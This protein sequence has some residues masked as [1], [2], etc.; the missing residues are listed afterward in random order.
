MQEREGGEPRRNDPRSGQRRGSDQYDEYNEGTDSSMTTRSP[1]APERQEDE[2]SRPESGGGWSGYVVPYRY[3][4]PGYRGVGYYSVMYQGAGEGEQAESESH[5]EQGSARYAQGSSW[6]PR[7]GASGG[8]RFGAG[9]AGRGPKGYQRSDERLKEEVSDRLMADDQIDASDIEVEVQKGEVT[10]TGTVPD[11]RSKRQ[12]ED[13]AEQVMGVRD[14][15]NQIR[16]KGGSGEGG[17]TDPS[18]SETRSVSGS[19]PG[20]ASSQQPTSDRSRSG[21]NQP[22]TANGRRRTTSSSR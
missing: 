4:G 2:W 12:A 1:N 6:A 21:E 15:M 10:L 3:Y 17:S 5:Q 18:I 16:V 20:T 22:T 11:R 14:V 7:S 19:R 9:F 13:C 8:G